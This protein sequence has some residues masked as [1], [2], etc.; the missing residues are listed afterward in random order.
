MNRTGCLILGF[1]LGGL[2]FGLVSFALFLNLSS[3][4]VVDARPQPA[5]AIVVLGGGDGSRFRKALQLESERIAGT[6]VLV[7]EKKSYWNHI[8]PDIC[9]RHEYRGAQLVCLEGST[10]TRTDA[11]LSLKCAR[12]KAWTSVVVVTAP[13]HTRRASIDFAKAYAGSGVLVTVVSSGDYGTAKPP[14]NKWWKDRYTL[15]TVWVEF[16]KLLHDLLGDWFE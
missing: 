1:V 11:E 12:A 7:D 8:A 9:S 13:Y 2:S 6:L 10:S 15:T 5:D 14:S 4:L 16:G 3:L